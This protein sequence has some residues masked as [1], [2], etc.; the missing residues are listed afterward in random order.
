MLIVQGILTAISRFAGKILSTAFGWAIQML[1]GRVSQDRQMIMNGIA[2]SSVLWLV[3]LIGVLYPPFGVWLLAFVPL[4]KWVDQN[5]VRLGML[6]I[7]LALPVGVGLLS[8]KLE[9]TQAD[10]Q[11]SSFL[12]TVGAGYTLTAG[13]AITLIVLTIIAPMLQ[14]RAMMKRWNVQNVPVIIETKDYLDTVAEIE[15]T[16][17]RAG[18]K[19]RRQEAGGMWTLPMRA[20]AVFTQREQARFMAGNMQILSEENMEIVVHPA[21]LAI[22]GPEAEVVQVRAL[23]VERLTFSPVHMTWDKEAM[24]QEDR[25]EA[26]W[27]EMSQ[28]A[29]E[30]IQEKAIPRLEEIERD[31]SR[32]KI[33]YEEW[34]VLYRVKLWVESALLRVA[35]GRPALSQTEEALSAAAEAQEREVAQGRKFLRERS[36]ET[37]KAGLLSLVGD[38]VAVVAFVRTLWTQRSRR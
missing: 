30:E 37:R 26:I 27:K 6:I 28:A 16:L 5:W 17:T 18:R 29:P 22:S 35:S 33:P 25:L 15:K 14:L 1:Y 31:I 11:K 36:Q 19:P 24:E 4:P 8:S 32:L 9:T 21:Y 3:V 13:V 20:M 12:K 38:V 2:F 7:A 23:V 34:E 10:A